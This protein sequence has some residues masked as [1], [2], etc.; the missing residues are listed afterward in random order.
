M[1][2]RKP[3]HE[4]YDAV[5]DFWPPA[6]M[7][8]FAY[9]LIKFTY[10]IAD[11]R[12]RRTKAEPLFHDIRDPDTRPPLMP[13]CEFWPNKYE[14][15]I[16]VRGHAHSYGGRPVTSGR[17]RISIGDHQRSIAVFGDR[18][19]EWRHGAVRFGRPQPY[20]SI[21]L[22]WDRAYGG[23]DPRVPINKDPLTVADMALLEYDHPGL[24]PRNPFGRGYVVMDTPAD[25]LLLP[26]L[27]DPE[28]LLTPKNIIVGDPARWYL[29]PLPAC[30]EYTSPIM[31]P[32][33]CWF[34]AE[35]WFHP[36]PGARLPE[37]EH[38]LLPLDFHALKGH[39]TDAPIIRQDGALGLVYPDLAANTPITLDGMHPELPKIAFHLPAPPALE[40]IIENKT[41]PARAQLGN[42][43]IEPDYPR[44]SLTYVARHGEMPRVF[45]PGIHAKIPLSVRI[46]GGPVVAYDCPPTLREQKKAAPAGP[47][48]KA[49]PPE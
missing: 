37:I 49:P 28:H 7:P 27:E 32:R 21:P 25:G 47:P 23:Y 41:Y 43:L 38:G 31:F 45:V 40:F 15:D 34:G 4:H 22:T 18:P 36:P 9:A 48:P 8:D 19:I 46:D 29:Q 24:Y 10:T 33:V 3:I 16:A 39:L 17:V 11:G 5:V 44:V 20:T 12:C 6:A 1:S 26:N 42:V 13:G 30:F 14:T 2:P 35:A